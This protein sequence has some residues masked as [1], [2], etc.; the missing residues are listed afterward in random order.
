MATEF[1]SVIT[2][3][4]PAA[5]YRFEHSALTTDTGAGGHTLTN[6]GTPAEDS[7]GKF[8]YAVALASGACYS[9]V[10]HADFKPT[11]AFT[12]G[13]WVK[14]SVTGVQKELFSSYSQNTNR[15]G[16]YMYIT[17]ANVGAFLTGK[18][19][20]TTIGT[21]YQTV[22]GVTN[23]CDGNW[24]FMVVT[25]N[26]T[27]LRFYV[28]GKIDSGNPVS[29]PNAPAYAETNYVRVGCKS[30]S[31]SV[32]DALTGSLDDVWLLNGRALSSTDIS[33]LYGTYPTTAA[34]YLTNYRNRK[35]FSGAV[36]V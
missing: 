4:V 7:S 25:W 19:T 13:L 24:H 32:V 26:T 36:S 11:G 1:N 10:D 15:A 5:Y 27:Y 35:R 16:I 2:R 33:N 6:I 30:N 8:G 14:T 23:V 22:G 34:N 29:W 9:A 28:D 3:F 18:N 12:M 31:G 17:A 20:G 21:D